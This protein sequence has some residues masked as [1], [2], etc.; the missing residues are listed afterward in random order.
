[1]L[2]VRKIAHA[3]LVKVTQSKIYGKATVT[4]FS[5]IDGPLPKAVSKSCSKVN[6]KKYGPIPCLGMK[7]GAPMPQSPSLAI[8]N[9][10]IRS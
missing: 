4:N 7:V 5:N 8:R 2:C 1:M 9:A 3:L 10:T 6:P